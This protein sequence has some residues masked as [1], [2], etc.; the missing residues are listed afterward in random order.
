MHDFK[1]VYLLDFFSLLPAPAGVIPSGL[2]K[3]ARM[4]ATPRTR[5]GDPAKRRSGSR[6]SVYSPHPRG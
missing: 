2:Q 6:L 3:N 4:L 1:I 5:G